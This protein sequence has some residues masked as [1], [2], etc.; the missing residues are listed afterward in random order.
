MAVAGEEHPEWW[1]VVVLVAAGG[2]SLSV[3]LGLYFGVPFRKNRL[4]VE[5]SATGIGITPQLPDGHPRKL[6]GDGCSDGIVRLKPV[7]FNN[8]EDQ[9]LSLSFALLAHFPDEEP[10]R[11]DHLGHLDDLPS[12]LNLG[13]I[14]GVTGELSFPWNRDLQAQMKNRETSDMF[15]LKII[16][17]PTG[18]EATV[19][20]P[21]VSVT[22]ET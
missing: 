17:L 7:R 21:G 6:L 10:M 20:V 4:S 9:Q 11:L 13:P 19:S 22:D 14:E 12:P 16:D 15:S 18:R 3:G 5:V 2:L 1:I 8:L